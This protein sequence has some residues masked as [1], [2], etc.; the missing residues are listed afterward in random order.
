MRIQGATVHLRTLAL[1]DVNKTHLD[2]R[3]DVEITQDLECR[4]SDKAR[5][6]LILFSIVMNDGGHY[7]GNIKIGPVSPKHGIANVSV[8]IGDEGYWK[9]GIAT[10]AIRLAT[11]Y[12]FSYLT[13]RRLTAA[14]STNDVAAVR[15]HEEAGFQIEGIRKTQSRSNGTHEDWAFMGMVAADWSAQLPLTLPIHR[16]AAEY[17][18]A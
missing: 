6:S 15:A 5:R 3:Q 13:L 18:A 14:A 16:P 2:T 9:K 4:I 8:R 11:R 10:E 12:A 17:L 1:I 7:V